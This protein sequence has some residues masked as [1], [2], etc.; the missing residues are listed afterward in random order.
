MP[1]QL[2][3]RE[4]SYFYRRLP[5]LIEVSATFPVGTVTTLRGANGSGKSTL[6]AVLAGLLRPSSG[7]VLLPARPGDRATVALVPQRSGAAESVPLTVHDVVDMGRWRSGHRRR[8]RAGRAADRA[9]VRD[10]LERVALSDLSGRLIGDLSGGQRQRALVAQALTRHADVL[11]LDEPTTGCDRE[12]IDLINRAVADEAAR[13]A[14]VVQAT[15]DPDAGRCDQLL[16]L[17]GGRIAG[18]GPPSRRSN[19]TG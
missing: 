8:T 5:A 17:N 1:D 13:G 12:S 10:A 7:T 18:I 2:C 14:V 3:V 6:V 15:H 11:L 4:V 19:R 9:A 16:T